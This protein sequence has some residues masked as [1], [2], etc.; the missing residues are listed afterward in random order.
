MPNTEHWIEEL[1]NTIDVRLKLREPLAA[2][3]SFRIGGPAD[4][5][6]EIGNIEQ[7]RELTS[8]CKSY[9][10]PLFIIGRGTNLLVSDRGI[11]GVVIKL[12]GDFTQMRFSP[13]KRGSQGRFENC[14]IA[15]AA[16]TLSRVSR[17]TALRGLAGL[18]YAF[19]IPGSLGGALIM[20]AGAESDSIDEV[21]EA[22]EVL[23]QNGSNPQTRLLNKNELEFAY[24]WSSLN[25]Y[26]CVMKAYLCMRPSSPEETIE[27]MKQILR[28][29][30][31][32]QPLSAASAGCVF[33]NPPGISAGRLIDQC[34]LKG[35][36]IGGAQ[37]ST[38][39]AN[40][41]INVGGAT[42]ADVLNLM[43]RITSTVRKNTG[44]DLEPEL[45]MV[46]EDG[47]K[48]V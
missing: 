21:V 39:H 31:T 17:L 27:R 6:A 18:E 19:G 43:D 36:Q 4:V 41:I 13:L 29:K 10:V 35:T 25:Q 37:V 14:I 26:I 30:K 47:C 2:H 33:K 11:R 46:G 15:G 16:V 3:T 42:A 32:A 48:Q 5:F 40:F 20:N 22:V 28:K 38:Q 1:S 44:I 7:L 12:C 8:F 24:R 45:K 9:S 23:A 34:G